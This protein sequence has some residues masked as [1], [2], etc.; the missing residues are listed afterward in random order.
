MRNYIINNLDYWMDYCKYI[1]SNFNG[2]IN[3]IFLAKDIVLGEEHPEF[4][5]T[6]LGSLIV[7]EVNIHLLDISKFCD[8]N[9]FNDEDK[10]KTILLFTILHELSH[11]DQDIDFLKTKNNRR[12]ILKY[13][14]ENDCNTLNFIMRN[15]DLVSSI[16][17]LN[18]SDKMLKF[19]RH[20]EPVV[21]FQER[22]MYTRIGNPYL[23]IISILTNITDENVYQIIVNERIHTIRVIFQK[24]GSI[25]SELPLMQYGRWIFPIQ[26]SSLLKH[27]VKH[28]YVMSRVLVTPNREMIV[29]IT[30]SC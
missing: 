25:I 10:I 24:Y 16:G 19:I 11:C 14:I 5:G 29:D 18:I 8:R 15:R 17:Q 30:E 12:E 22:L 6:I 4:K 3:T 26:D 7:D 28:K 21:P 23:K 1:F 27:A 2:R 13:E 9:N 20:K